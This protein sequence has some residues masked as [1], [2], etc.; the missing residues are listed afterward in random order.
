MSSFN[1][2][3]E[4]VRFIT[5]AGCALVGG[6]VILCLILDGLISFLGYV[7]EEDKALR[8]KEAGELRKDIIYIDNRLKLIENKRQA[9]VCKRV[10]VKCKN[11]S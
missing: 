8:I 5:M 2:F 9:C 7:K 10:E 11:L 3:N 1:S 4:F 6:G